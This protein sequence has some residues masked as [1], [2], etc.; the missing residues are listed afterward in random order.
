MPR[1]IADSPEVELRENAEFL[2]AIL[3]LR[4]GQTL[5]NER[6]RRAQ[7]IQ[8]VEGGRMERRGAGFPA[9]VCAGLEYR[10]RYI[11]ADEVRCSDEPYGSGTCNQNAVVGTHWICGI[12]ALV[13]T[14]AHF[15]AS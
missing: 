9:Q 1:H 2:A 14:L 7:L 8:H 4:C 12:P 5:S 11:P 3:E 10:H 6:L 15:A 13:M